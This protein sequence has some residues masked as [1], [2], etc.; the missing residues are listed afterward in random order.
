LRV[1]Q[2]DDL[3]LITEEVMSAPSIALLQT[4]PTFNGRTDGAAALSKSV[5]VRPR[6]KSNTLGVGGV[7]TLPES[8]VSEYQRPV[9][10]VDTEQK[11]VNLREAA[12]FVED[13]NA[14]AKARE[15]TLSSKSMNGPKIDSFSPQALQ[16]KEL[17]EKHEVDILEKHEVG[18]QEK[19]EVGIQEKNEV[20]IQEKNEGHQEPKAVAAAKEPAGQKPA[21]AKVSDEISTAQV[22]AQLNLEQAKASNKKDPQDFVKETIKRKQDEAAQNVNPDKNIQKPKSQEKNI[23]GLE[24]PAK[25]KVEKFQKKDR[26]IQNLLKDNKV[27][28]TRQKQN[29][30]DNRVD[31][32]EKVEES[33]QIRRFDRQKQSNFQKTGIVR[34]KE[35]I[36]AQ[37]KR[38]EDRQRKELFSQSAKIRKDSKLARVEARGIDDNA[39]Q[40][41]IGNLEVAKRQSQ[42]NREVSERNKK[43]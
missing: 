36:A 18:I 37:I 13:N 23:R 26:Q 7:N 39:R 1:G 16:V 21:T 5:G 20:G 34:S 33:V 10:A 24:D 15:M 25:N 12:R 4:P 19:N 22:A 41:Q 29:I 9:G 40:R 28:T 42:R 3:V 35:S 14:R 30:A 27:K 6:A 2:R 43:R 8:S 32:K 38:T 17:K 31:Q 11:A